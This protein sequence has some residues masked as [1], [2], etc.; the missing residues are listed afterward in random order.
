MPADGGEK[1]NSGDR[2]GAL[3]NFGKPTGELGTIE[4]G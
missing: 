2:V 4:N 1:L 3:G